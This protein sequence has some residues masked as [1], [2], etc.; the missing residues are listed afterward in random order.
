MNNPFNL[1]LVYRVTLE[2]SLEEFL[3]TADSRLGEIYEL[4]RT[5]SIK[6]SR[7]AL[8]ALLKESDQSIKNIKTQLNDLKIIS[9]KLA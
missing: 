6:E 5:Q 7:S 2:Y 8:Q 3:S 4:N 9:T 1:V